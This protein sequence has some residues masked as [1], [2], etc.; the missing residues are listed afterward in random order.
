MPPKRIDDW[1]PTSR[2]PRL[3]KAG[4]RSIKHA[5]Y[6]C[7]CQWDEAETLTGAH[8]IKKEVAGGVVGRIYSV[9]IGA[10]VSPTP[11][12]FATV[13]LGKPP[14]PGRT[15]SQD[16]APLIFA[17]RRITPESTVSPTREMVWK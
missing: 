15:V 3:V 8:L 2:Q 7:R 13:W 10:R 1:S 12:A 9:A 4:G 6:D 5:R 16:A 14:C 11:M 17:A